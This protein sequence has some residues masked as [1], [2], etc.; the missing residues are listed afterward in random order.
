MRIAIVVSACAAL[1]A[2]ARAD[3]P[4]V[5]PG[6]APAP[7]PAPGVTPSAVS[8]VVP[9]PTLTGSIVGFEVR[10]DSKVKP[11][12]LGYLS[13]TEIGDPIGP[14]DVAAIEQALLS[15]E[16]FEQISVTLEA[17][18]GDPSPGVIVV[19]NA[20][21][22][23]SWIIA[24]AAFALP[25][26]LALGVGYA[27]NDF[28]G[29]AQKFLL[30]G[31][32]GTHT[33][34]FFGTFLD[35]AVRGTKLTWRTDVYAYQRSIDEYVN[36]R[37]DASSSAIGRSTTATYVSAAALIGWNFRW[38]LA[39]DLRL[40]GAYIYF[41]DPKD[42]DGQPLPSPEKDGFDVTLQARLTID[43]RHRRY[44]VT[45]GSY[46]Q[47]QLE[48]SVPGIDSYGYQYA[49]F[50]AYQSWRLFQDHELEL[51]GI[52]AA[53]RHMPMHEELTL[54]GASDLRG[55]SVDQFRGDVRTVFRAEYSVP[56]YRWR[57]LA[58]RAIG[59]Y[60]AGY[61]GFHHPRADDRAYLP[62]Q[63]GAGYVR[64]DVGAG[65]RIYLNNIV[66]PLLGLDLGYGIEGHSPEVYFE[67]G[68][69]DF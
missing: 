54:G 52:A 58:F 2:V 57:F 44:G 64:T 33:S 36:P 34:L 61:T 65:L 28:R 51:R 48:P 21:D 35:P 47:L 12:T 8:P 59:F 16:L 63:L 9:S 24:P 7:L 39:T 37:D 66:L 30:Y 20:T 53:A 38:W 46:V 10:G 15:S 6:P 55:Y 14:D 11:K 22:K 32:I 26:N 49:L 67:V 68:L 29:L 19:A 25:G 27:E 62:S 45:W 17:A 4:T 31:Q 1:S 50:R 43:H 3:P 40:R 69:T 18:P 23:H 42:A 41:R 56:V 13:H 60:D 5:I